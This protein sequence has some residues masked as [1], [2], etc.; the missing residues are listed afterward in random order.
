MGTTQ[1]IPAF[2]IFV[3]ASWTAILALVG[4]TS[5]QA[6]GGLTV[7]YLL[8]YALWFFCGGVLS[9]GISTIFTL[10]IFN[11]GLLFHALATAIVYIEARVTLEPSFRKA[12]LQHL[13]AIL[14]P[15]IVLIYLIVSQ[16]RYATIY[17]TT[18][19]MDLYYRPPGGTLLSHFLYLPC[20][21]FIA[22]MGVVL[23]RAT[24][25][26]KNTKK[27]AYS[28]TYTAHGAIINIAQN[29]LWLV[30]RAFSLRLLW[31][32][33]LLS[34][35]VII[36]EFLMTVKDL[37]VLIS[38][39]AMSQKPNYAK[40]S[41]EETDIASIGARL[42]RAIVDEKMYQRED[43][44]LA[45]LASQLEITPHQLSEYLNTQAKKNFTSF[46]NSYRIEEAK[47]LLLDPD[48]LVVEI[49]YQVGFNTRASFNRV[50][51]DEEG[52]TPTEYKKRHT[53]PLSEG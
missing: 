22:E 12:W 2:G 30:D 15:V 32:L 49:A 39:A 25:I 38:Q 28:I 42:K 29:L 1:L 33:Y 26:G 34:G 8:A 48:K 21:V 20:L 16:A 53:R 45:E 44:K 51:K 10:S 50:F 41:L 6:K 9:L 52:I 19:V 46:I 27:P 23:H 5:K 24:I 37:S 31:Y 43:I 11:L 17:A 7:L 13:P 3:S 36:L 35:L 18:S 4:S 47:T 14:Y 40:A